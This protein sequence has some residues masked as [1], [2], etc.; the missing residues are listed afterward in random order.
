M[1]D[2]LMLPDGDARPLSDGM[3]I[4][5]AEDCDLRLPDPAVSR[6]HATIHHGEY[7]RW[8][9]EDLDSRN[10]TFVDTTRLVAGV[11]TR[12]RDG[13]HLGVA[14][15]TLVVSLPAMVSDPE[16]TTS[17]ELPA[18]T[19]AAELSPYQL[20]VVRHLATPWLSGGEPASNAAI[21]A[22]LGTPAATDAVKAALRRI[23]VKVGLTGAPDGGKRREL[24][25]IARERG[26]L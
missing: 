14:N 4:G 13:G 16:S 11:R 19:H 12:L 3:V 8:Y 6:R 2:A 24:C 18:L 9:V 20:T 10:G 17:L 7:G 1:V 25:R 21:A 15:I 23:Y 22:A 26:W 5:R